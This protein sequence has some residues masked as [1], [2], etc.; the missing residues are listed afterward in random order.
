MA[1]RGV[2]ARWPRPSQ[3]VGGPL[4]RRLLAALDAAEARRRRRARPPVGGDARRAGRRASRGSASVDLRVEDHPEPL[5]ELRRLLDLATPTRWR[6][7]P[8]SSSARA[9]TTRR[10]SSTAA[11][12]ELA[13]GNHEL[14]FWAGL[15]AAQAG[16]WTRRS[17]AVRAAI[18]IGRGWRELLER[19]EPEI[20]PSAAAV[21][22][23]L[24][25]DLRCGVL[26]R[27]R[28]RG[29]GAVALRCPHF[30]TTS[31]SCNR[32]HLCYSVARAIIA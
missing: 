30:G 31:G 26:G 9:A 2:A 21:R 28:R 27:L 10:A 19:L 7:R 12:A 5:A 24:G 8:T 13:P 17:S 11:R 14:L 6:A 20:A 1:S 23:A 32:N 3:A 16:D 4:A 15:A 22:A 18:A 25:T 29:A